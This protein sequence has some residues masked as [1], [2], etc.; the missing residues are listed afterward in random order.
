[1]WKKLGDFSAKRGT[2][3]ALLFYFI[4]GAAGVFLCGVLTSLIIEISALETFEE[5]KMLAY[6][7]APIIA[8]IYTFI[9]SIFI[10]GAKQLQKDAFA[11]L[12]AIVGAFA[13]MSLGLIFGFIPVAIL[14]AIS[15][16]KQAAA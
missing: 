13:S 5:V 9:I 14:S 11:I 4:Y 8:G 12:C 3:E 7:V 16:Q 2:W 15:P 10:I 1:M 6:R